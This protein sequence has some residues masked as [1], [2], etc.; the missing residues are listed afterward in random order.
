MNISDIEI[1]KLYVSHMNV[2]KTLRGIKD[3]TSIS[4]LANDIVMNGLIN[5][6]TVLYNNTNNKYEIIA[7]QRRFLAMKKLNKDAITCNI[8]QVDPHKAEQISLVEN[9]QRN[10][11]TTCDKVKA[12]AK[13]YEANNKNVDSLLSKINVSNITI[14]KYLKLRDLPEE[15]LNLLDMKSEICDKISIDVA[16]ELTKLQNNKSNIL[17]LLSSLND[18]TNGQKLELLKLLNNKDGDKDGDKD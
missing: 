10:P 18:L 13:L 12:F 2:R 8:L 14:Q 17:E 4:D 3:E 9:I 15:V 11:M 16:L 7:G 1:S 6:I 5:P